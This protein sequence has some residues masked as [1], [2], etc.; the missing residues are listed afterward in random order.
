MG[1][2]VNSQS[3]RSILTIVH[4]SILASSIYFQGGKKPLK[5]KEEDESK[6]NG[7]KPPNA[8]KTQDAKKCMGFRGRFK[9]FPKE[10]E[11]Y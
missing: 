10:M 5:G 11:Q 1:D 2:Y 6:W 9:L 7:I 4:H 3:P 8:S